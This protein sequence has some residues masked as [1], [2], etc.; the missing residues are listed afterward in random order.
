MSVPT[1]RRAD[2]ARHRLLRPVAE[3]RCE[4]D[5]GERQRRRAEQHPEREPRVH[6]A[7]LAVPDRA[8]RLEDRPV[9]DVGAD[10]RLRVEAEQQDQDRRHQRPAAHAGHAHEDPD[11]QAGEGELPGHGDE[12]STMPAPT[13]SLV[14]SSIT[15]KAP[16]ARLRA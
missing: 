7:E 14:D 5:A 3:A 16:V 13:V 2:D 1:M 11:E 15:M 8:E 6:G 9:E 10:R 12:C 4:L